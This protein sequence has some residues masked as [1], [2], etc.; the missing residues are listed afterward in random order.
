MFFAQ[1]QLNNVMFGAFRFA[2]ADVFVE[3]GLWYYFN[4]PEQASVV[5]QLIASTVIILNKSAVIWHPGIEVTYNKGNEKLWF[6]DEKTPYAHF[7]FVSLSSQ[8][9]LCWD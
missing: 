4:M 6:T 9:T 7:L 5:G 1:L 8:T 2:S 3:C